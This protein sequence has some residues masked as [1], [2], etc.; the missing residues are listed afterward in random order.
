MARFYKKRTENKGM[1]PGSLIFIGKK[2]IEEP[3][4]E[5][6]DYGPDHLDEFTVSTLKEVEHLRNTSS[7]TWI[8]IYGIHDTELIKQVGELFPV[9]SLIL[10]D[11][12]NT[13]Q[14]AKAEEIE[15]CLFIA[16]KM[17]T[18]E[19]ESKQVTS[20]QLSI[21]VHKKFLITFQE[22]PGD[23]FDSVR[24]RIR[25]AKGRLRK[26]G[27]DY[28]AYALVDT[29]VDSYVYLVEHV[30]E[31]IEELELKIL[32]DSD[33]NIV[34]EINVYKRELHFMNKLIKPV[35]DLSRNLQKLVME[36]DHFDKR[37]LPFLKDL[38]DLITHVIESLDTYR[39][40]TSDYLNLYNSMV[41]NKMN[42]V[43][44]VL[45]IFASIF[46]PITFFAGVYG[47]NFDFL[48]ELHFKWA[49]PIF[50]IVVLGVVA[51]MLFY[52]RRKKWL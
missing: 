4:I 3:V 49:Y 8:N 17:L 38:D 10:E 14:R 42:D 26:L 37:T 30:G 5:V 35:R 45:T 16:M 29:V 13:G 15:E 11:V 12:L 32:D 43:M 7:V 48:P 6:I 2:K 22:R 39:D 31:H 28:L 51:T 20:E 34:H 46:I 19:K 33:E 25:G 23:T 24:E 36:T 40:L 52:F 47:M 27:T 1:P 18:F 50:W 44:R 41:S 21:V 9:H